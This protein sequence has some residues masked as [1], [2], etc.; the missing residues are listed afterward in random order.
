MER[1]G[2]PGA[3]ERSEMNVSRFRLMRNISA[4]WIGLATI[5]LVGIFLTPFILHHLGPVAFGLW[6]LITTLTGYY[7]LLDFGIRNAVLR[8]AARFEILSTAF[9]T[10]AM[11]GGVILLIAIVGAWQLEHLIRLPG[12]WVSQAKLL[13]LVVGV[14][15]AISFP[16]SVFG[17]V[18]E[19]LQHFTWIASVQIVG[20]LIRAGLIVAALRAGHGVLWIGVITVAV[21]AAASLAY[22]CVALKV[23]PHM[24]L[25][26]RYVKPRTL[27]ML[28]TFGVITFWIGIAQ[29]LRFEADTLV[30][31]AFL[32]VEAI[33]LF[34]IAGKLVGYATDLV[35]NLAQVFTPVFSYLDATGDRVQMRKTLVI[36]NRYSSFIAFSIAAV[37][38]VM[39]KSIIE[40]W[41]GAEYVSSYVILV[42]L[43]VPSALYLAQAAS[44]KV[45]YGMARHHALAWMLLA[46]GVA[47][48]T[49]SIVLVRRYGILGVA[50]GTA[51]PLLI[52]SVVFLPLHMC[53]VVGMRLSEYLRDAHLY[54]L[55]LAGTLGAC[56]WVVGRWV[57]SGTYAGVLLQLAM[58]TALCALGVVTSRYVLASFARLR[59]VE[60]AEIVQPTA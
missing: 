56:L 32:S 3:R 49:L 13:L 60:K 26:W 16:L 54:P 35:Q 29:K 31:G 51:V 15:T 41:V 42:T 50:I 47:N 40:A 24:R 4:N 45:L 8:Y 21:N 22:V 20:A 7:G 5:M 10:Y 36:G 18:L 33:A 17:G 44:T 23:C 27:H 1:L 11:I 37:L 25:R 43:M 34:A 6:V 48:L 2:D 58:G 59:S 52:T 19:G 28:G 30:I 53:R 55:T 12:E 9:F 57:H 39:G 38:L 46:E 14:G